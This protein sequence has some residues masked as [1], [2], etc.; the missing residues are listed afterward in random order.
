ME[1]SLFS[2]K[3]E[4]PVVFI[5][6][7]PRSGSTYLFQLIT[8]VLKVYYPDKLVN[9]LAAHGLGKLGFFLASRYQNSLSGHGCFT[10]NYG[11]VPGLRPFAPSEAGRLFHPAFPLGREELSCLPIEVELNKFLETLAV[12]TKRNDHPLLLKNLELS[13]WIQTLT[14]LP[15]RAKF[16]HIKRDPLY[17]AQSILIARRQRNIAPD[18]GWSVMPRGWESLSYADE[19]ELVVRQVLDLDR[20]LNLDLE[21]YAAKDSVTQ[22]SYEALTKKPE[23]VV[24]SLETFME[25]HVFRRN[26]AAFPAAIDGNKFVLPEVELQR[27]RSYL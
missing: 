15:I 13:G 23:A 18:Q 9:K 14:S 22:V 8:H 25:E 24:E 10:S 5:L 11:S 4:V 16:I 12:V 27:L 2:N 6:G 3:Q 26:S 21:R 20:Q 1:S 19:Y 7:A 17:N